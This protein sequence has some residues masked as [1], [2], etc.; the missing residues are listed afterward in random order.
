MMPGNFLWI[1]GGTLR[2]IMADIFPFFET[3]HDKDGNRLFLGAEES[4]VALDDV[5]GADCDDVRRLGMPPGI[6]TAANDLAMFRGKTFLFVSAED[7]AN[8]CAGIGLAKREMVPNDKRLAAALPG[9]G[10]MSVRLAAIRTG[11]H[12]IDGTADEVNLAANRAFKCR[13]VGQPILFQARLPG[14]EIFGFHF[15]VPSTSLI[16]SSVNP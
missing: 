1:C 4:R 11:P 3:T 8:F 5:A 14:V 15:A 10:N 2:P 6:E 9:A 7:T 12:R 16:S 13:V